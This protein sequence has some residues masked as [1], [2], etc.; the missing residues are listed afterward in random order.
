MASVTQVGVLDSL[1]HH[2]HLFTELAPAV[3]HA[4]S[5]V[6]RA[7]AARAAQNPAVQNPGQEAAPGPGAAEPPGKTAAP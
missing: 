1:R 4:R 2:K 3:E 6:T 7:R 5:H